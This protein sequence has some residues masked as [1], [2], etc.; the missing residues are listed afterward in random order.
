MTHDYKR[1]DT[2]TLF[3]TLDVK[4]GV[5]IGEC[6][7]RHRAKE[8]LRFLRRIDRAVLKPRYVHLVLNNYATHKTPEVKAWLSR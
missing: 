6:L 8:F 4:S 3:A 1:K 7:P 5:V 2:T